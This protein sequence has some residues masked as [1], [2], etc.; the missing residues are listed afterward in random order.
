METRKPCYCK[1]YSQFLSSTRLSFLLS[2][3]HS[4]LSTRLHP[5]DAV[6]VFQ[7]LQHAEF[8][9]GEGRR[10]GG[11]QPRRLVPADFEGQETT[12]QQPCRGARQQAQDEARAELPA[13]DQGQVWLPDTH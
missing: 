12:G 9:A 6:A 5:E 4:A 11:Q 10:G 7:V 2:T 3:Q 8:G 1:H 13:P